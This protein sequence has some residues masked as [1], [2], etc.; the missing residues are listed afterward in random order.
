M[1]QECVRADNSGG[2]EDFNIQNVK[3]YFVTQSTILVAIIVLL[4]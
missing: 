4:L 1:Y 2:S 3:N